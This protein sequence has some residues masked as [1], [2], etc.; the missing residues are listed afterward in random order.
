MKICAECKAKFPTTIKIDGKLKN[1]GS[2][3]YCLKC[4]PFGQHNTRNPNRSSKK[5][6][7]CTACNVEF[8]ITEFYKRKRGDWAAECKKC[9]IKRLRI[10]QRENKKIL[11][12]E[13]GGKCTSCGYNKSLSALS[14]HHVDPATKSFGI[15][16]HLSYNIDELREEAKKCI[17]LCCNCHAEEHE[18][19]I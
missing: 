19:D 15:G 10:K 5:N 4:S 13:A 12:Q 3:K 17:L 1:L 9:N 14:F 2:R 18:E 8:P 7:I 16:N 6:K 11:V